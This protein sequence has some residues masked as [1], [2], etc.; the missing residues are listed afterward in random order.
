MIELVD[1]N[2]NLLGEKAGAKAK[3]TR[4]GRRGG[5]KAGDEPIAISAPEVKATKAPAKEEEK[6]PEP[7]AE[8]AVAEEIIETTDESPVADAEEPAADNTDSED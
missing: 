3:G 7:V 4:R 1:F 8:E 5:K 2:L 6:A